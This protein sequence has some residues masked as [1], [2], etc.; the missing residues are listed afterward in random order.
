MTQTDVRAELGTIEKLLI[1]WLI[2]MHAFNTE[3][4][5]LT[6]ITWIEPEEVQV[7]AAPKAAAE[8]RRAPQVTP[9]QTSR[10]R[11][12]EN[13][14]RKPDVAEIAPEPQKLDALDNTISER[15][16]SLQRREH[17]KPA[18]IASI[19]TPKPV[20]KP[21]LAGV[22]TKV[23][24]PKAESLVRREGTA[25]TPIELSRS[26]SRI[27]KAD[28]L[29]APPTSDRPARA[30]AQTSDASREL[31]GA[32]MTGPVADRPIV[33]YESPDYPDWAKT[34]GVEGSVMIYFVVLA[35]GRVKENVMVQRTSGFADFDQNA[36]TA[37]L[38]WR[39]ERLDAGKTG[40]Q[41]GTILFHYRL[42]SVN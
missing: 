10:A 16:L 37:I 27:Q 31:A 11:T 26:K 35:D 15:L 20:S 42:R 4:Q 7:A 30:P 40:E 36:V 32:R 41:W 21:T 25:S 17:E 19:N 9:K 2:L 34:E 18:P 29:V 24:R 5:T 12:T 22:D 13:I 33:S 28:V 6:E 3:S 39:F 23:S 14:Q 8:P 1:M 38:A